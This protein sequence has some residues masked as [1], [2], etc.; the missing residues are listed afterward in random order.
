MR[1]SS[2]GVSPILPTLLAGVALL[3]VF[4]LVERDRARAGR[5]VL[6]HLSVFSVRT[7]SLGV[8]TAF[9][10]SLGE[11]GLLFVLPLLLQGALGYD[12]L[13]TGWLM[14]AL[15]A[16]TFLA[17]GLVPQLVHRVG[18]TN[19]VRIGIAMEA[20]SVGALALFTPANGWANR[21]WR[22]SSA[23]ARL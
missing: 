18:K 7:F 20:V 15:A 22:R 11:F 10:V 9:L 16:G 23:S 14:M 2:G 12:A 1:T 8:A 17:S 19:L 5:P 21:N 13:G 4:L 3:A 6:V